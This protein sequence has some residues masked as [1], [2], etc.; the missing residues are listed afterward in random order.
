[1]VN[2]EVFG[3]QLSQQ[4]KPVAACVVETGSGGVR[5]LQTL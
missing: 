1:M 5:S 2:M 3:S 4:V